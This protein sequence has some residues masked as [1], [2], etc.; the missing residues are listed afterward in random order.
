MRAD[1]ETGGGELF[2]AGGGELPDA[3]PAELSGARGL[4][5]GGLFGRRHDVVL[6]GEDL[7]LSRAE[8]LEELVVLGIQIAESERHS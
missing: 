3:T 6:E 5:P 4:S 1:L 7:R 2:D 8:Q